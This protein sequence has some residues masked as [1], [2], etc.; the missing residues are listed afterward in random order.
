MRKLFIGCLL[1]SCCV[2]S[3]QAQVFQQTFRL[4]QPDPKRGL[5]SNTVT[6]IVVTDLA[7][8]FGTGRGLSKTVN[9]GLLF[10]SFDRE[11]GLGKGGVSGLAVSDSVIWV[12]TGF[13]TSTSVGV[14]SA[15]GGL[16]YS[17]DQGGSWHFVPQPGVTP[18]QN[19]TFDIALRKNPAA[20]SSYEVWITSFGGG[21]RKS[22]DLGASWTV[23]TPDSFIFDP[24]A[25]LNHR[26]F[27]VR[28][29]DGTLWVGTAGGIN[30]STDGGVTWTNFR[31]DSTRIDQSISGN[32]VVAIAQQKHNGRTIIWA[33]TRETTVESGDQTEFRGISW[34]P[35]QGFTWQTALAGETIHNIAFDDSVVYAAADQGLFKS[36]DFGLN[37][38]LFPTIANPTGTRQILATEAFD[39]GVTRDHTLWVGTSNGLAK[40]S[41]NGATWEIFQIFPPTGTDGEPRTY[42]YPNPFSPGVHNRLRGD[43]HVRFQ[44]NTRNETRVTIKIYD[45][46]MQQVATVVEDVARPANGDFYETWN[47]KTARGE[48]VHN[49]VY[50]YRLE[51]EG[52]GTFWG[53]L[54]ILN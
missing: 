29:T 45:F 7:I 37:W 17:L 33:G 48:Q 54:I 16:A 34:S 38:F 6:D 43:G 23:V 1:L 22:D 47:G 52:D 31:H 44:Y 46:A 51:L 15:G 35:D 19:I 26:A 5:A 39:A 12:A 25:H 53:K 11:H 10:E 8:W 32:F 3:G 21:L 28:N 13:D 42:A 24:N 36:N 9:E 4:D 49:G 2:P 41:D 40:S 14:V 27:S 50:F 18:A 30:R 20:I